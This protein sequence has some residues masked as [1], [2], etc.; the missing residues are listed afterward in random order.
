MKKI[1]AL[2]FSV[3]D[4]TRSKTLVYSSR[5]GHVYDIDRFQHPNTNKEG[6]LI[7]HPNGPSPSES[8]LRNSTPTGRDLEY[9]FSEDSRHS[10]IPK[11]KLYEQMAPFKIGT[12]KGWEPPR[13]TS[14]F[15]AII[16]GL[17]AFK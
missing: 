16:A 3:Q 6:K 1:V 10:H 11:T 9:I 13:Q 8:A 4:V 12:L 14:I 5:N 15:K 17:F 7:F 2:Q